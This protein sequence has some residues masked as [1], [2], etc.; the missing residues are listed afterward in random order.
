MIDERTMRGRIVAGAMRLAAGRPWREVTLRDIAEAAGVSLA[1]MRGELASKGLILAAF[2]RA[3]DDQVLAAAPRFTSDQTPRDRLFD[4]VMSRFD[5]L[6]P[7]K[8]ALKSI[9]ASGLPDP[10]L[11]K[12]LCASQAWML[13]AANIGSDGLIG[14]ARVTGLGTVYASVF[15]TWLEDDDPGHART[16]AALDKRLERGEQ[17]LGVVEDMCRTA[18]RA[19]SLLRCAPRTKAEKSPDTTPPPAAAAGAV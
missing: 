11:I 18:C 13:A 15:R 19:V 2:A 17:A 7:Y 14:A 1:E 8:P 4:V 3:I 12:S 9:A 5:A 16:M 6:A 10:A